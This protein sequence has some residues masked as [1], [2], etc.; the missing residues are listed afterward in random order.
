MRIK[1]LHEFEGLTADMVRA[2]LR[3][4]GWMLTV[5]EYG[6]GPV[7]VSGN[8][9]R[10]SDSRTQTEAGLE[11]LILISKVSMQSL[12]SEINPR[13]RPGLPSSS[14]VRTHENGEGWWCART[15]GGILRMG[16]FTPMMGFTIEAL[17]GWQTASAHE[18]ATW[19][20][21]PCD[22]HGNKVRL[23]AD[24]KRRG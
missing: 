13:M 23:A 9:K 24:D 16:K 21:W 18:V 11:W 8:G 22:A 17:H 14:E 5:D 10:I 20:F 7:W 15:P 4:N 19:S 12:L 6:T 3:A 1:D 2:W